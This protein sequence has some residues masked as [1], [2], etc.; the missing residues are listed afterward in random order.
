MALCMTFVAW[1]FLMTQVVYRSSYNYDIANRDSVYRVEARMRHHAASLPTASEG[2]AKGM[3]E[4]DGF[5]KLSQPLAMCLKRLPCV[6]GIVGV[7]DA[8]VGLDN[9]GL[10][11]IYSYQSSMQGFVYNAMPPDMEMLGL[12]MVCGSLTFA[13][14]GMGG[15][16]I[17][18]SYAL[19]LFGRADDTRGMRIAWQIANSPKVQV[20]G[21]Y[22]DLDENSVIPNGVYHTSSHVFD[23]WWGVAI[24]NVFV[25][26]RDTEERQVL[27]LDA[28][29]MAEEMRRELHEVFA[30]DSAFEANYKD[31]E[32][33]LTPVTTDGRLLATTNSNI[34]FVY[35]LAA[36]LILVI[37][38]VVS[39]GIAMS[40]APQQMKMLSTLRVLGVS[41][42]N[43][44]MRII[45][46]CVARALLACL[47]A[48]FLII[49][50]SHRQWTNDVFSAPTSVDI[51]Y[52][53]QLLSWMAC[54]ALAVGVLSGIWPAVYATR[55]PL[56]MTIRGRFALSV[57][58]RIIR[59]VML[60]LQF[61]LTFASAM[62]CA[63]VF[64]QNR[65]LFRHDY[66]FD[67]DNLLYAMEIVHPDFNLNSWQRDNDVTHDRMGAQ[68]DSVERLML[69]DKDVD[70]VCRTDIVPLVHC[71]SSQA[72]DY[73]SVTHTFNSIPFVNCNVDMS[74]FT[75]LHINVE[76]KVI[77]ARR[78]ETF[79]I[80]MPQARNTTK[81]EEVYLQSGS[82][83]T[84][85]EKE[86][87]RIKGETVGLTVTMP[88]D[89]TSTD[90]SHMFTVH[91][92]RYY[93]EYIMVH[94]KPGAD[95]RAAAKRLYSI[96]NRIHGL[97]RQFAD[98]SPEYRSQMREMLRFHD[99]DA[100][101]NSHYEVQLRFEVPMLLISLCCIIITLI[102]LIGITTI[103]RRYML[104]STAIRRVLGTTT[105]ELMMLQ[106]RH[107]GWIL[108]ISAIIGMPAGYWLSRYWVATFALHT[109]VPWWIP[110]AIFVVVYALVLLL[111]A[112]Q[113]L[114]F[115]TKDLTL[116][117]K[118][119]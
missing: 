70:G 48:L 51:P 46:R 6:D 55:H 50:S 18:E 82:T 3:D 66:G 11:E 107:Y 47:V 67:K 111:V 91:P 79:R 88:D 109:D 71:N 93:G 23:G 22:K 87:W 110:L 105:A 72:Y 94:L 69:A 103:E 113:N 44:R 106:V 28:E 112:V 97:E 95:K 31:I 92:D 78:G 65:H 75:T 2:V 25:T 52:N 118:T 62:Y 29:G 114:L 64:L 32:F 86:N 20:V 42:W 77:T 68:L 58:G 37:A 24:M 16:I 119:E 34:Y 83:F 19:K 36:L 73:D 43:V 5:G 117:I 108:I 8:H 21:V 40:E 9:S 38:F 98:D 104:R 100:E 39:M 49:A 33:R 90:K 13:D 4:D 85:V 12:T 59:T 102:G 30:A 74:F 7:T 56:T 63:V 17:P 96:R 60:G 53:T 45:I 15:V 27:T 101:L 81:S 80:V 116:A 89:R 76:P 26:L 99:Y 61:A 54:I 14:E 1:Y 35:E 10:T 115:S 41:K 57:G 84:K